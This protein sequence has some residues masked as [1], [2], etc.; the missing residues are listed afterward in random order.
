M[1]EVERTNCLLGIKQVDTYSVAIMVSEIS[2]SEIFDA[3]PLELYFLLRKGFEVA[4]EMGKLPEKV[5]TLFTTELDI[6]DLK[7]SYEDLV[8]NFHEFVLIR[9][10]K[11]DK[12][13]SKYLLHYVAYSHSSSNELMSTTQ[14]KLLYKQLPRRYSTTGNIIRKL[15]E[16]DN[17]M[18]LAEAI[19][20]LSE[21]TDATIGFLLQEFL[22]E[23]LSPIRTEHRVEELLAG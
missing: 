13:N 22:S 23:E 20:I 10:A 17:E 18:R 1:S 2:S 19:S 21:E 7:A 8:L 4:R 9:L 3:V 14:M 5:L 15:G 6:Y 12:N 11:V 16:E